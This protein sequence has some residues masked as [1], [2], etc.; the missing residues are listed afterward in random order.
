MAAKS[1]YCLYLGQLDIS[2]IQGIHRC[3]I[4]LC[5]DIQEVCHLVWQVEA[6]DVTQ[7]CSMMS[8][9][10]PRYVFVCTVFCTLVRQQCEIK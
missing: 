4:Q 2:L 1:R 3:T 10:L 6:D 9:L 5:G 7:M 8:Q